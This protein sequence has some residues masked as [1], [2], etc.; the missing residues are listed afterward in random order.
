M[1]CVKMMIPQSTQA[2]QDRNGIELAASNP[3]GVIGGRI[4][5]LESVGDGAMGDLPSVDVEAMTQMQISS[6]LTSF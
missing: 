4:G 3:D 5:K 2:E 1:I 6:A